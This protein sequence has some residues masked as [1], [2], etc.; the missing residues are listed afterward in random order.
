MKE[1]YKGVQNLQYLQ[2]KHFRRKREYEKFKEEYNEKGWFE[3]AEDAK[4]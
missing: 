3:P 1:Y 2:V 4:T